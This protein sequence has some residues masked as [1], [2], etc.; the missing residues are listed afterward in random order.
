MC[1]ALAIL[2][3][4]SRQYSVTIGEDHHHR[5]QI[6][7]SII[8]EQSVRNDDPLATA[9]QLTTT[10]ITDDFPGFG[11]AWMSQ[12]PPL[13]GIESGP[14]D[15]GGEKCEGTLSSFSLIATLNPKSVGCY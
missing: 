9:I 3:I 8:F 2:H 12:W 14:V 4:S 15:R 1:Q 6:V 7:A 11:V 5:R 10:R 13:R